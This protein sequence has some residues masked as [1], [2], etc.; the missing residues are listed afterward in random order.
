[1]RCVTEI[2]KGVDVNGKDATAARAVSDV[3]R[4]SSLSFVRLFG[5]IAHDMFVDVA[6]G[7]PPRQLG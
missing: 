6:I 2:G 5:K 3:I 4:H 1:V 7:V